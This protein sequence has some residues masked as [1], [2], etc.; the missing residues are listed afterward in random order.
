MHWIFAFKY[1]TVACKLEQMKSGANPDKYNLW[2]FVAFAIG[3]VSNIAAGLVTGIVTYPQIS[4]QARQSLEI[5][6]TVFV[7]PLIMSCIFLGDAFRRFRSMTDDTQTINNK[8]IGIL[9]VAFGAFVICIL[10]Q[11]I[12]ALF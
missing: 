6:I 1:W 5:A 8:K 4:A 12:G 9:S 10:A 2:Y 7:L 11:T 3:A